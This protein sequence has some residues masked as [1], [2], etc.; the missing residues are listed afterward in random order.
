VTGEERS[1]LAAT[2]NVS[3]E[4]YESYLK[5]R[6]S[7]GNSLPDVEKGIAYYKDAIHEDPSFAPAYVGLAEAYQK[8]A[9]VFIGARAEEVRP[10]VVTAAAKALQLDPDLAEGHALL[11][12][13]YQKRWQWKEAE[14]EYKRALA[15]NPNDPIARLDYA[16]WLVCRGHTDEAIAWARSALELDP[17]GDSGAQ[18]GWLLFQ[19]HRFDEA[20]R[21]LRSVLGVHPNDATAL[22]YLGFVLTANG[23]SQD[24]VP[25]LEKAVSLSNRSPA[26]LA[27]L[28]RAYAQAGRRPDALRL[29]AEMQQRRTRGYVPAGAFVNAYLGLGEND[30]AMTFLEQA[31]KEQ[32]NILQYLTCH[33]FFAPVRD[34]PRF[35]DLVHRVGLG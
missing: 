4:V 25:V 28:I 3:P 31:Y 30:K 23:H 16:N 19:A 24:A 21:E 17:L 26:V 1:R 35:K 15:L 6:F 27:I 10:E 14:V 8:M 20:E 9:T 34:D 18:I 2:R 5:G 22:W 13:V 33:P 7:N 29:L 32:S 12:D 11:A